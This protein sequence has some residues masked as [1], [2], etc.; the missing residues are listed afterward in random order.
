MD[1]AFDLQ[2]RQ[3]RRSLA[4]TIA[5]CADQ[6]LTA[7][8]EE[9]DEIKRRRGMVEE[10]FRLMHEAQAENGGL[11]DR[12][13]DQD[14]WQRGQRLLEEAE[15]DT[16]APL[17]PQLRSADLRPSLSIAAR[18]SE[19]E[20]ERL[21]AAVVKRRSSLVRGRVRERQS[22]AGPDAGG[23]RLLIYI[24]EEN[25]ADGAAKYASHGFFDVDN[26][27]PWDL[28]IAFS[29]GTLLSWVPPQLVELAQKGIEV[30]PESCIAWLA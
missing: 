25:L 4:E 3:L 14:K 5:W 13:G 20:Q 29:G 19:S 24:P 9:S 23:G 16:I 15:I 12:L 11:W 26:V 10:A 7:V 8:G 6:H 17:S 30:N 18:L 2:E 1:F 21:V 28:W 27:P 22:I